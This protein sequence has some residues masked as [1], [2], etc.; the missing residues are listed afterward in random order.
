[1]VVVILAQEPEGLS[2][3]SEASARLADLGV[4]YAAILKDPDGVAVV[5]EGRRF[6]P[7]ASASSALHAMGAGSSQRQLEPIAQMSVR[8]EDP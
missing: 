4:T 7:G 8:N 2:L 5:L 1:M 3:G 6:D